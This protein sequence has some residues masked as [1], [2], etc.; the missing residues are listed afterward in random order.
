MHKSQIPVASP[1]RRACVRLLGLVLVL[2]GLVLPPLPAMAQDGLVRV[3]VSDPYWIGVYFNNVDLAG[4][5]KL[6]RTESNIDFG[7]GNGSPDS[8]IHNDFFSAR[9]TRYLYL[10]EGVYRFTATADDGMRIWIDDQQILNEWRE[11]GESTFVVDRALSTGHHQVRIEYFEATGAATARFR[12]ERVGSGQPPP[13]INAWR[14]DFFNNRDLAGDPALVRNDSDINFA[15]GWASPAPG[16]IQSDNFSVRWT[17]SLDFPTGNYRFTVTV[18]DGARLWVNNALIIDEWREQAARTFE[19]DIWLPGGSVPLRLEYF[20]ATQDATIRFSWRRLDGD[21]GGGG[22]GGGG[23]DDSGDDDDAWRARYYNNA[24][25]DPSFD[26]PVV[27]E[28]HEDRINN[29]WGAGAPDSRVNSDWFAAR[30]TRKVWFPEG[31]T[32]FTVD[33]DDGARLY[34]DGRRV[35]DKWFA[36]PRTRYRISINLSRGVHDL[37]LDYMEQTANASIR[38]TYSTNETYPAPVGNIITCVPPQPQNYAWIKLYRLDGNNR[39]Y[40]TGRGIGSIEASGFLKIDGLP[41]DR[42]RFGDVGEPYKIEQ[43]VDGQIRQ[44]T[45]DFQNGQPEFRVRA[46]ADNY[47]PWGCAP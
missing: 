24:P 4:A 13:A 38:L 28:R 25:G 15:W 5:P 36:Q 42:G 3:A 6:T 47:T 41:V 46:F 10:E 31:R 1:W 14:G 20:D 27:F 39:W 33:V 8:V 19:S 11:Q 7:W 9:W 26:D 34:V 22:G 18:D 23:D 16:T 12:W 37:R 43:W 21:G 35:L 32:T 44:S 29:D 40:S 45:G 30:Y 17:R 2:G